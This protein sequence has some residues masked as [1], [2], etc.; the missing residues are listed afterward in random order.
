MDT[1]FLFQ[2]NETFLEIVLMVIQYLKQLMVMT[3]ILK[4]CMV[5][6]MLHIFYNLKKN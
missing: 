6:F 1:K 5:N 4:N 3:F 2:N